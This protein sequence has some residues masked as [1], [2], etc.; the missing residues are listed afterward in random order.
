MT[1]TDDRISDREL[2]LGGLLVW[3]AIFGGAL[4]GLGQLAGWPAQPALPDH[5]PS[6]NVIQVWLNSPL[7]GI[8]VLLPVALSIGWLVWA[9]TAA[10]I[11]LQVLVDLLDAATRGAAWVGS[12]RL[13][14]SWLVIPP[15]RRAVDASL[16]G[17]LLARVLVQPAAALETTSMPSASVVSIAPVHWGDTGP[18]ASTPSTDGAIGNARTEIVAFASDDWQR[19]DT[20][21]DS[22]REVI[23][24]VQRGDTLWALGERFY[25]DP[26]GGAERIFEA[27]QGRQ[28]ADGRVFD[29]RGLIFEKWTLRI[30][31]PS[32]GIERTTDGTWWYT[33]QPGD[34]LSGIGA[35][36]LG[37][38]N[39]WHEIFQMNR[40][41]QAPDGHVLLNPNI[42]WAGLRLRLPLNGPA[43]LPATVEP[44]AESPPAP[45]RAVPPAAAVEPHGQGDSPAQDTR[46]ASEASAPSSVAQTAAPTP[47]PVQPASAEATP[48]IHAPPTVQSVEQVRTGSS[49][50]VSPAAAALGAAGLAA[51]ALAASR[52]VV[53]KRKPGRNPDG[54]ESDVQIQ[55]GFADVDPVEDLARRLARTSDPASAIASVWGQA[56]AAIFEEQL[57]PDQRR[58]TQGVTVATTKHGR[59]STTLVLAAPVAAR[60]HLVHNMRAAA[61]RAFGSQVDVDGLVGQDGDVLIRVTWDPR[62]PIDGRVLELVGTSAA[63]CAWPA[64]CLVPAFVTYDRQHLAISWHTIRN[65]LIAASTGQGADVPLTALVAAL[66]SVRAPEDLGLV[67]IAR[68]HT[69]PTEIGLLPHG[70]LDV[71]DPANPEAV[72]HAL[73]DVKLEIDRRRQAG[74]TDE[75]DLVVVVRELGDLD[76]EAMATAAAIATTGPEHGVRLVAA[77]ERPA[78]ELLKVCPFMDRL[79]TRLV[80]QTATEEDS[81]ALLGMPGA[82][83][84]GAGGHGR[85]R[86]EGRTPQHG[87]AHRVSADNLA[88]LLHMMGTRATGVP[89]VR[90][91]AVI[92]GSGEPVDPA[93]RAAEPGE[94]REGEAADALQEVAASGGTGAQNAL[95]RPVASPTWASPLLQTL[96]AAPIRVRCFG[97][98]A[99][100][101]GDRVLEIGN[102]ELLLLLAIHPITGIQAELLADMLW[103]KPPDDVLG[104]LRTKRYTL[105]GELRRLVPDLPGD[106]LPGS[107]THG[108]KA[109]R[110][111]PAVVSSDVHEFT[112]L[113]RC[114]GKLEPPAAVEAYEAALRLYQGDLLESSGMPNYRWMYNA[115]PQVGLGLSSDFRLRQKQA[116]LRLAELLARGPED[117][118]ARAEE[119]YLSLCAEDLDDER[120]WIALFRVYERTGS[121]LGLEGAVRRLRNAL[122]EL[123][124]TE[125][126]D[127]D[128]VP[129]PDNLERLVKQIRQRI[130]SGGATQSADS[131]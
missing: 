5:L 1:M 7:V 27:N 71:I 77:S 92:P 57:T 123:G 131:D 32:Q 24:T 89:V 54:P 33:V 118:L 128:K 23:Y 18:S 56:Y 107:A 13:A 65:V 76:A 10:S 88:R 28:Q 63:A 90:D 114:A 119:L 34:T 35:R 6:W 95:R 43:A 115:D 64:P 121:S 81:V 98:S 99:T 14:T 93:D 124:L 62:R 125:L 112:E 59:T 85:L 111:D 50:S 82:E 130:G 70:V 116:R 69:L 122:I 113:L 26:A 37:D 51:A 106:P 8:E 79:S 67:I 48:T 42:I 68:P 53:Y 102:P 44:P 25:G 49:Y 109:V 46:V 104:G 31:E 86:V 100:W 20:A 15:I 80:L 120:L 105:R 96:R 19:P 2:G 66:A 84:I 78:A 36:L 30:P 47:G 101:C 29:R 83:Y 38:P 11:A 40:G 61:E 41:A 117:G 97:A 17:L 9:L 52:L 126:T 110:L 3:L 103:D 129:L 94:G 45:P 127:I 72:Q 91:H 75:A 12:L 21:S 22:T 60:P 16:S 58:D 73:Q 108:E 55:D 87:W 74:P 39:R 4:A